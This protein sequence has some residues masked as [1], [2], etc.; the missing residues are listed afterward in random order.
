ME[1]AKQTSCTWDFC[2]ENKFDSGSGATPQ[3]GRR[4]RR[5]GADDDVDFVPSSSVVRPSSICKVKT[6]E[7]SYD[8]SFR[9]K[10][11][12]LSFQLLQKLMMKYA[13]L[14]AAEAC[15]LKDKY[16]PITQTRKMGWQTPQNQKLVNCCKTM[17]MN[18]IV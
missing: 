2:L 16:L 10:Q 3:T 13:H 17:N 15:Q 11:K 18:H 8:T 6:G 4:R 12:I 14:L 9:K 5:D 1:M 7:W